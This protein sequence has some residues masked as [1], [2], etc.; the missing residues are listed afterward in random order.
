MFYLHLCTHHSVPLDALEVPPLVLRRRKIDLADW[1]PQL[2]DGVVLTEAV[3]VVHG[4]HEG[5]GHH[6][7]VGDLQQE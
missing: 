4:E 2:T 6:L 5:L 3:K 1:Q 7:A